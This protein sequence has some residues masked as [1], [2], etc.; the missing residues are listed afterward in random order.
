MFLP[1]E[2][3]EPQGNR[4]NTWFRSLLKKLTVKLEPDIF[5]DYEHSDPLLRARTQH[6]VFVRLL[7]PE[8]Q[9]QYLERCWSLSRYDLGQ[10]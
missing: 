7:T 10:Q 9:I 4:I 8:Q 5:V 6:S 3:P 2:Q 1:L